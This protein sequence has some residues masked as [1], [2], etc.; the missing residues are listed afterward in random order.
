MSEIACF[1]NDSWSIMVPGFMASAL[2]PYLITFTPLIMMLSGWARAYR[3]HNTEPLHPFAF[4][5]LAIVTALATIAAASF[6]YFELRPVHLPPWQSPK[7]LC[8]A[9]SSYSAQRAW[10]LAFLR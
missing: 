5:L 1:A 3:K 8:L 7:S 2:V 9:G 10:L 6:V 4:T